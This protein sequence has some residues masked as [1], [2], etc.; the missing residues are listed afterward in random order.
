MRSSTKGTLY[1]LPPSIL[2]P[3]IRTLL[4]AAVLAAA[5]LGV[6]PLFGMLSAERH[7]YEEMSLR[8]APRIVCAPPPV[9]Y[10]PSR[11]PSPAPGRI[12]RP[13]LPSGPPRP[14]PVRLVEPM[15]AMFSLPVTSLDVDVG[16]VSFDFEIERPPVMPAPEP[17]AHEPPAPPVREPMRPDSPPRAI[18]TTEPTYP[19]HARRSGIEGY[20]DLVFRVTAEGKATDIRVQRS[21]PG[22]VFVAAAKAAVRRWRFAPATRNGRPVATRAKQRLTFQLTD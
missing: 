7:E 1:P 16:D 18:F 9:E 10:T 8:P 19:A 11:C 3:G 20:V 21:E 22:D 2:R 15:S 12:R 6:L 4:T 13:R 14:R 5:T 17:P